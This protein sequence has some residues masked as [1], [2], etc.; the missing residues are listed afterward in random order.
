MEKGLLTRY[1]NHENR[2]WTGEFFYFFAPD[3]LVDLEW[4]GARAGLQRSAVT[5]FQKT[6]L[7]SRCG[8]YSGPILIL[9]NAR[10]QQGK[11]KGCIWLCI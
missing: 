9:T 11:H 1:Y 4:F 10:T 3:W 6:A 5:Y 2:I 8:G 7:S